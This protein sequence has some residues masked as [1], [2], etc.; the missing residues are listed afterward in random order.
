M[1]DGERSG[2]RSH[3]VIRIEL[4]KESRNGEFDWKGVAR[5]HPREPKYIDLNS[6]G[7]HHCIIP[8]A[9]TT[10]EIYFNMPASLRIEVFPSNLQRMIDFYSKVLKF[11]L[12]K[13]E[14]NYAYLQRDSIFIGAIET[15]SDET[16]EQKASYRRPFKGIELVIEVD[17]L[18][19]ERNSIV[20]K[21]WKLEEDIQL[22]PWG[23]YDFRLQCPDGYY[24]RFTG[25]GSKA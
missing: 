25:R 10:H 11:S 6:P 2:E 16:L 21:G 22:Q 4:V 15:E 12:I 9:N 1:L 23:L 8:N 24:L 20:E 7:T 17:D 14:G 19:A 3:F 13:R 18:E 5:A